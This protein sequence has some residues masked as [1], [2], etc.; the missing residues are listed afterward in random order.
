M[1][2]PA[3]VPDTNVEKRAEKMEVDAPEGPAPPPSREDSGGAKDDLKDQSKARCSSQPGGLD[4]G[5]KAR[6]VEESAPVPERIRTSAE[7]LKEQEL[8]RVMRTGKWCIHS[9]LGTMVCYTALME[10]TDA[11]TGGDET[12]GICVQYI[13]HVCEGFACNDTTL[14]AARDLRNMYIALRS[15]PTDV[16]RIEGELAAVKRQ[17]QD[18]QDQNWELQKDLVKLAAE[19]SA[20]QS[21]ATKAWQFSTENQRRAEKA[22]AALI[23]EIRN[24]ERVDGSRA[25][26]TPNTTQKDS[27]A[28]ATKVAG[29]ARIEVPIKGECVDGS[30]DTPVETDA[31]TASNGEDIQM[32]EPQ[33]PKAIVQLP[34]TDWTKLSGIPQ[35]ILERC[36]QPATARPPPRG[37]WAL[38]KHGVPATIE[39]YKKAMK[40]MH[41]HE[42]YAVGL[43]VFSVYATARDALA[44]GNTLTDLQ[45]WAFEYFTMPEWLWKEFKTF[46]KPE[47]SIS[48]NRSFWH[49]ATRPTFINGIQAWAAFYQ[50][51]GCEPEGLPFLDDFNSMDARLLRGYVL[52]M[53]VGYPKKGVVPSAKDRDNAFTVT[54]AL[55]SVM[56][57]H[58]AYT[59]L[60]KSEN[61]HVANTVKLEL[62]PLAVEAHVTD[63][64]VAKRLA[65]MGVTVNM[66]NDAYMYGRSLLDEM[67]SKPRSSAQQEE[68]ISLRA[69]VM[70]VEA[71]RGRPP[72]KVADYGEVLTRSPGLPWSHTT[73]NWAQEKGPLI[74]NIPVLLADGS[75][76]KL[77]MYPLRGALTGPSLPSPAVR[78]GNANRRGVPPSRGVSPGR[79]RGTP[80]YHA[81]SA[82]RNL[83]SPANPQSRVSMP[84]AAATAST[85]STTMFGSV[86]AM[87][88]N[89]VPSSSTTINPQSI[90]ASM[91][92]PTITQTSHITHEQQPPLGLWPSTNGQ[93]SRV[94]H[95]YTIAPT[96]SF[97]QQQQSMPYGSTSAFA[98]N[99]ANH[100]SHS[101]SP[102]SASINAAGH[103]LSGLSLEAYD[104][105]MGAMDYSLYSSEPVWEL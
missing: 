15:G 48:A 103:A 11:G 22:E 79:G 4:G 85:S 56:L 78:G 29:G 87:S 3:T 23:D 14:D 96:G 19:R 40:Y 63:V 1:A 34:A 9:V 81:P 20:F 43:T 61:L 2:E 70:E 12:C 86:P 105:D 17:L 42:C 89:F 88:N 75:V 83:N 8:R 68:L 10:T 102:G 90:Y 66:V 18:E 41:D 94:P 5:E 36:L 49:R 24:S 58:D 57:Y 21:D 64:Q 82:P 74:D 91:H 98:L 45:Q 80:S 84:P 50:R 59:D 95:Q 52:M 39:D 104:A 25:R 27:R 72:G 47:L 60:I 28:S 13:Q 31:N 71:T 6:V 46:H 101:P 35:L 44:T 7:A 54:T 97:H 51:Q 100:F 76:K 55:M 99:D 92:A 53:S 93:Q 16:A 77:T 62:W 67:I 33:P 32:E 37:T 69:S 26:K 30:V 65:A 73:L 38:D